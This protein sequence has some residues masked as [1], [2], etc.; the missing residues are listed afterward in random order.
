MGTELLY[1]ITC[2]AL[3]MFVEVFILSF[4]LYVCF[5][6]V[7]IRKEHIASFCYSGTGKEMR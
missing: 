2:L 4:F 5:L 3:H 7:L 1:F 6:V